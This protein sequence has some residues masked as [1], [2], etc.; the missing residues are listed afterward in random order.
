VGWARLAY[1]VW[2]ETRTP[3]IP[4]PLNLESTRW[5]ERGVRPQIFLSA[6]LLGEESLTRRSH[7]THCRGCLRKD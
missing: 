5:R 3:L 4:A 1:S 6:L 7:R 2:R